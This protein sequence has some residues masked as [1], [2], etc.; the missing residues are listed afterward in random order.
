LAPVD[1]RSLSEFTDLV[2]IEATVDWGIGGASFSVALDALPIAV[3]AV[4]ASSL[5]VSARYRLSFG[6]TGRQPDV[7]V[8]AAIAYGT[9]PSNV[10][11]GAK[12]TVPVFGDPLTVAEGGIV[13][14][15]PALASEVD[16][17]FHGDVGSSVDISLITT[18]PGA[19]AITSTVLRGQVFHLPAKRNERSPD[20]RSYGPHRFRHDHLVLPLL[21]RG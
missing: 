8:S 15:A 1:G 12:R 6:A 20:R 5:K 16:F 18:D 3:M 19:P 2:D 9:R 7:R 17:F 10:V 13:L 14:E 4:P 11:R 21:T